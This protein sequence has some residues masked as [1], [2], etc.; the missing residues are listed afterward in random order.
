MFIT[1]HLSEETPKDCKRR[2]QY[3]S[4]S[5][6][7]VGEV[8]DPDGKVLSRSRNDPPVSATVSARTREA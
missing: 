5:S 4:G 6:K 1:S 7:N 8:L 2:E 3:L